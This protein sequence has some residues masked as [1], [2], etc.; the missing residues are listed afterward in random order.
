MRLTVY[1]ASDDLVEFEGLV[2][3]TDPAD[4]IASNGAEF[5]VY[6]ADG[7][8]YFFLASPSGDRLRLYPI[9]TA[10]G[11]WAFA[12]AIDDEDGPLPPDVKIGA[13]GYTTRLEIGADGQE[14]EIF[15]KAPQ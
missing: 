13:S 12:V 15:W 4:A 8:G 9:Y 1:G 3:N 6:D 7:K 11:T 5:P 14:W 2:I 10:N